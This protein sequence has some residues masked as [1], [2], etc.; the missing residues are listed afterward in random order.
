MGVVLPKVDVM[1]L[2]LG[3]VVVGFAVVVVVG[4]VSDIIV[5][6]V[7]GIVTV[8]ESSV[9]APVISISVVVIIRVDGVEITSSTAWYWLIQLLAS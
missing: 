5:V 8:P 3:R 4:V 6:D 9:V 1:G 7:I 2:V